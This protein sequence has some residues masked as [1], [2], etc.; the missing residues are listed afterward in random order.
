MVDLHL[1]VMEKEVVAG[2]DCRGDKII[3]DATLG[4]GGH[5]EAICR[6]LSPAGRLIGIDWDEAALKRASSRLKRFSGQVVLV[7]AD[8]CRLKEILHEK[9]FPRVDGILID[10]GASTLQLL[11]PERGFSFHHEGSL[12]MRMDRRA[13]LTA[14]KLVNSSSVEELTAIFY[15]F[16]EERWSKRIAA[17]IVARREQ[18]GQFTNSLELARVVREAIPARFRRR[19]GH[20][21]RKVFQ[22]L[23]IAVNSELENIATVLPQAVECLAPGGRLCLIAYHSL[24]DRL[25]KNF[26]REQSGRCSCPPGR[27]CLCETEATLK[28]LTGRAL[29]P[30]AGEVENNPRARSARLRAAERRG[31]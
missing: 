20:P 18:V 25:V 31:V 6:T 7:H 3:V 15:R 16:G 10:L 29:R 11:D 24:E 2:L 17:A 12:D 13:G 19:G 9:G 23:R 22:S 4:D 1:P 26:F 14:K 30:Q 5:A 27:P 21:A 8:Y 28:I